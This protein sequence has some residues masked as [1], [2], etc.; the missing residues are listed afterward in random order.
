MSDWATSSKS[1]I[2]QDFITES[3]HVCFVK[4][5]IT[6]IVLYGEIMKEKTA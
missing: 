3:L 4:A 1:D 6:H 5:F 2:H